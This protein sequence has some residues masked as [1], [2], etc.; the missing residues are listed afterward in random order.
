LIDTER[1]QDYQSAKGECGQKSALAVSRAS[2]W[3][4]D[5]VQA[6]LNCAIAVIEAMGSISYARATVSSLEHDSFRS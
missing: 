4:D 1:S 2:R 6:R 5:N 3:L